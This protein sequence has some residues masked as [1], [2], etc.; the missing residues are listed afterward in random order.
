MKHVVNFFSKTNI[1]GIVLNVNLESSLKEG[2]CASRGVFATMIIKCSTKI[3]SWKLFLKNDA[4]K[5]SLILSIAVYAK[6][7]A[8]EPSQQ[9]VVICRNQVFTNP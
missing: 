8:L 2:V 5:Q 3:K 9:L 6:S 7:M 4:N 1:I